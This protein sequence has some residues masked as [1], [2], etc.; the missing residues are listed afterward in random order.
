MAQLMPLDSKLKLLI[1]F[2]M[3]IK[4]DVKATI[5]HYIVTHT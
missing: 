3:P 2:N 1:N 4:I 5:I